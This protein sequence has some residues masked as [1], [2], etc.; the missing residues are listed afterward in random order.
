MIVAVVMTDEHS[1][2]PGLEISGGTSILG[3]H[4]E[5]VAVGVV[6]AGS[7]DDLI[8]DFFSTLPGS[9]E[10]VSCVVAGITCPYG[11]DSADSLRSL[12]NNK[13]EHII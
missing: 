10:P 11:I 9:K 2:K 3:E 13:T 5:V 12:K 7:A 1:G 8:V 6:I 4:F